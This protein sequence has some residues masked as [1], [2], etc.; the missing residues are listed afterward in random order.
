MKLI[1][2]VVIP[3]LLLAL[4]AA[5]IQEPLATFTG[6]VKELTGKTLVLETQDTNELPFVCTHK[7]R[8]Y[9]GKKQIKA[10]DIKPG[11]P[12]SIETK[13]FRDG[14]L[15]AINVRLERKKPS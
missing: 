8:Y 13:R 7:T 5:Q 9:D 10:S 11:D 1:P 14:E 2:R 4:A 6:T 3:G 15:E 12:V